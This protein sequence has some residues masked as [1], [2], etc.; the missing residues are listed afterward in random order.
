[1]L[2]RPLLLLC[3]LLLAGQACKRPKPPS[4]TRLPEGLSMN[5]TWDWNGV[6]GTGQS[7]SVGVEG[8]PVRAIQPSYRNLK[9][10]VGQRS[11]PDTG[12]RSQRTS[13]V[14]LCEPIRPLTTGFPRT[15]P[16]NIYGETPHT[17]MASQITALVLRGASAGADYVSV[18][19]VV[20]ES[21]QPLEVLAKG[22]PSGQGVGQAYRASL[23]EVGEIVR[24]AREAE[25][26]FGVAAI[27][28]THGE[29]DAENPDY[30]Q[31]LLRLWREYAADLTELTGQTREPLLLVTQQGSSPPRAGTAAGSALA[32]LAASRA[33]P[34]RV[35]CVGPRYQYEYSL[36][37]VHL[38]ALSYDR[39]GE[40]Y[41]QVYFE[42][43]VKGSAWQPLSPIAAEHREGAVSV[44]MHVPVPP[45]VW[46]T[47]LPE[48]HPAPDHP[49][50]RGH[51]FELFA[52]GKPAR[53]DAVELDGSRVTLRSRATGRLLVRY[54][55]TAAAAPRPKGTW[56][57]G[58]LRDSDPFV[59]STTKT[60]QPNYAVSFELEVP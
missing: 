57:W 30:A 58:R 48:P 17:C 56:R 52:D 7:L 36:D 51:G 20:G 49:W 53:I 33:S 8:R 10:D 31:A 35:V 42:R 50:A 34:G 41:G 5:E 15:Y 3:A 28:L 4:A 40:K 60:P 23:F 6:I 9:L 55:V 26:S 25:R 27:V 16:R 45:L 14:P 24:L 2:W 39:L 44:E 11:F 29:S 1:M 38:P 37:A 13:L 19:S 47:S 54:A 43:I 22:A 46:D 21:G 18:H 32:A 59:G 12:D